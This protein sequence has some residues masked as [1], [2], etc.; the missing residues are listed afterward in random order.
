MDPVTEVASPIVIP[1]WTQ[2]S[3]IAPMTAIILIIIGCAVVVVRYIMNDHIKSLKE[4][5]EYLKTLPKGN[6]NDRN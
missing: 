6:D 3:K 2:L 4:F 1:T 5:I